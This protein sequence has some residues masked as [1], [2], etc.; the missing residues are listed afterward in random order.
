M[1]K[2]R[3]TKDET[4]EQVEVTS[5]T[6]NKSSSLPKRKNKKKTLPEPKSEMDESMASPKT[7]QILHKEMDH[8]PSVSNKRR[9]HSFDQDAKKKEIKKDKNHSPYTLHCTSWQ[10]TIQYFYPPHLRTLPNH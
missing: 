2:K 1:K 9:H 6:K 10:Y 4:D 8:A 5:P 7:P 3:E